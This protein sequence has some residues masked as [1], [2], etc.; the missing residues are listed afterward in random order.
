MNFAVVEFTNFKLNLLIRVKKAQIDICN[1]KI[2]LN[3]SSKYSS[4]A[5]IK[6]NE[7]P[8]APLIPP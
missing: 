4:L 8:M 6:A 3:L 5:T 1:N 7:I 2:C